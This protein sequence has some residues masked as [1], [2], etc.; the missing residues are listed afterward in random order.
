MARRSQGRTSPFIAVITGTDSGDF[1]GAAP[2]PPW[3]KSR[4]AT[5]S[6]QFVKDD[7]VYTTSYGH[8]W[9]T[10]QVNDDSPSFVFFTDPALHSHDVSVSRECKQDLGS[11]FEGGELTQLV[12]RP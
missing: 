7:S 11:I 2:P 4:R 6:P 12:S 9:E 1:G 10:P 3:H 5:F 8:C